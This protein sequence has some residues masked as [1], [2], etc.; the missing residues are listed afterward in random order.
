MLQYTATHWLTYMRSRVF[1]RFRVR[2]FVYP[3]TGTHVVTPRSRL[4]ISSTVTLQSDVLVIRQC[5]EAAGRPCASV[6]C[7]TWC[8][9]AD[10]SPQ[11]SHPSSRPA[12]LYFPEQAIR[13]TCSS[14]FVFVLNRKLFLCSHVHAGRR[15]MTA[16]TFITS[17]MIP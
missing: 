16:K 9:Y 8:G 12:G 1:F 11:T 5:G 7:P 10:L 17:N 15:Q 14:F 2:T 13:P 3:P 4:C 6:W